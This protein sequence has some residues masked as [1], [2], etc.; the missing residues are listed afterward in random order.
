[1]NKR[2]ILDPS[3]RILPPVAMERP[4]YPKSRP[5]RIKKNSSAQRIMSESPEISD[6]EFPLHVTMEEQYDMATWRMYH[7]I[8]QHRQRG[9][10]NNNNSPYSTTAYDSSSSIESTSDLYAA[11]KAQR[12]VPMD[13]DVV[14]DGMFYMEL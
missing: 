4:S 13:V 14:A 9:Q 5:I 1:M 12:K 3:K 2:R 7:R 11:T 6:S 10:S 8:T